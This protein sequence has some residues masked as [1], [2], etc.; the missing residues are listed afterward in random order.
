ML[1]QLA[2]DAVVLLHFGFI[3]FVLLGGLLAYKW[4]CVIWLH[5]PAVIWGAVIV[6]AGWVCPLTPLENKL[7]VAGGGTH[8]SSSFIEH[9]ILPVIYPAG[10]SRELQINLGITLVLVNVL[11][12]LGLFIKYKKGL[13]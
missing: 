11:I 7:R 8:Y 4:L 6:L 3:L 13:R 2:A 5:L 10:L 9:Y 12:Y 1:Y